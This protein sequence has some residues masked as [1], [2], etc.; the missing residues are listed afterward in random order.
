MSKATKKQAGEEARRSPADV[1]CLYRA[2]QVHAL[3][4]LVWSRL[5]AG[6]AP[7]GPAWVHPETAVRPPGVPVGP[8]SGV[9]YW[10]P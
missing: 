5:A 4:G 9:T 6:P 2:H 8:F 10:Y 1:E 3:A 7:W